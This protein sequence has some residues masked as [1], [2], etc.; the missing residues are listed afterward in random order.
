MKNGFGISHWN[1]I[2]QPSRFVFGYYVIDLRMID[3][4]GVSL[5]GKYL[6]IHSY[7]VYFYCI[8]KGIIK[9]AASFCDK[10][11]ACNLSGLKMANKRQSYTIICVLLNFHHYAAVV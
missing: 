4:V 1:R 6:L 5:P 10:D 9:Q 11:A 2:A 3:D 7:S 8:Y